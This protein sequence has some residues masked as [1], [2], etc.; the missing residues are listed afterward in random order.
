MGK[1]TLLAPEE[2]GRHWGLRHFAGEG[3]LKER[4]RTLGWV[5]N[6]SYKAGVLV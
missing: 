2:N 1:F 4:K 5:W 3:R 6:Q